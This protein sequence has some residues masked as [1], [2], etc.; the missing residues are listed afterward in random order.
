MLLESL[1]ALNEEAG[2][3]LWNAVRS[4]QPFLR[5]RSISST[6]SGQGCDISTSLPP[7]ALEAAASFPSSRPR[8][9]ARSG[10]GAAIGCRDR[11]SS[12]SLRTKSSRESGR[13]GPEGGRK[14]DSRRSEPLAGIRKAER[15]RCIR[16]ALA[17]RTGSILCLPVLGCKPS[18]YP[19]GKNAEV[20]QRL[21]GGL[22]NVRF[23]LFFGYEMIN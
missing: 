12:S 1:E 22:H 7:P 17:G 20:G 16:R 8:S 14:W 21:M 11:S 18:P 5:R 10:R 19:G 3:D 6:H 13:L 9:G 2:E 15:R 4:K 23:F